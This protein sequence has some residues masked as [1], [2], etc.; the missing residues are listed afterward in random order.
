MFRS[1]FPLFLFV[2]SNIE[3]LQP[4]PFKIKSYLENPRCISQMI[5]F[6][7]TKIDGDVSIAKQNDFRVGKNAGQVPVAGK[8]L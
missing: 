4:Q 6:C 5:C 7:A 2:S 1:T 3:G 8:M